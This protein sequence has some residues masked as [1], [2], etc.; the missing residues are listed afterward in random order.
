LCLCPLENLAICW[1]CPKQCG[2][3]HIIVAGQD[4]VGAVAVCRCTPPN[5]PNIHLT[6]DEAT[7]LRVERA[8]LGRAI[9]RA[10]QCDPKHIDLAL[11]ETFQIGSWSSDSIPV[12]VT[13]QSEPE[14]FRRV[15]AELVA[16]LQKPFIL[17][18]P[19]S[20]H[21]DAACRE[22]LT[23]AH[24]EFFDLKSLL[25]FDDLGA[26]Q[27]L[28]APA[29]LF[30]PLTTK[31]CRVVI[32]QSAPPIPRP[33]YALRKHCGV[34]NL[35]FEGEEAYIKHERALFYVAYLL[36]HPNES[37][38]A[39][40]LVA[41]I[42]EIYRQQLGLPAITDPATG[43][44]VVLESHARLQERSLALDDVQAMRALYKKQKELEAILDDA[45]E[46]EPVK[47]EALRELESIL[48]Y[49]SKNAGRS[50]DA[51][52]RAAQA[53]RKSIKRLRD[54]LS[55][56]ETPEGSPHHA[57]R[58]FAAFLQQNLLLPS[59]K[60]GMSGRLVYHPP[61]GIVFD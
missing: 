30:A 12:I 6:I 49:E 10:L 59:A 38:H 48:A 13:V 57:L 16:R 53:V 61:S 28:R 21:M 7:P 37:F 55:T 35:V 31:I 41:R 19:T 11:P 46:S 3:T 24:A 29:D 15:T 47:A 56:T 18:A 36:K 51:A 32:P 50:R 60:S 44:S 58:Q 9:A 14:V 5:C 23:H 25:S 45:S 34:W 27:P 22:L 54:R 1:D 52:H 42:P 26:L 43:K 20:R 40:D 33:K 4:G 39:L 8:R 2:C 17:L